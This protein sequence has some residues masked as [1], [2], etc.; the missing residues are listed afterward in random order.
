[1]KSSSPALQIL[2]GPKA[3][4]HLR[5]KGL[6]PTDIA[7]IPGAAGGPK[8]LLLCELDKYVFGSWLPSQPR[9]RSLIGASIGAWR[10]ACACANDPVKAF[11][12]LVQLYMQEQ[13]YSATPSRPEISRVMRKLLSQVMHPLREAA[14]NHSHHRLHILVNR[15]V[16]ALHPAT[17]RHKPGFVRACIANLRGRHHLA[18]HMQRIVFHQGQTST[19]FFSQMFDAFTTH[20][21]PLTADNFDD[22]LLASGSIPLVMEAM[23]DIQGA[24]PGWYW[25]GGIIDYHLHLPYEKLDGLTLYPHFSD[26]IIPG[27]LDKF[28]AWR[29]ARGSWLDTLILLCPSK[30]FVKSLPNGK[31]PDRKDFNRHGNNWQAREKE[32]KKS[33]SAA[34]QLADDFHEIIEKDRWAALAKP[35]HSSLMQK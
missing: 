22:A 10:M 32:W 4:Q 5:E 26:R 35:L 8:G 16:G 31:I 12:D 15:G 1:M 19:P 13:R 6:S 24:P 9:S 2:A 23:R 17:Q 28:L 27:W 30:E 29:K 21:V 11:D 33:L 18:Q 34:Q 7:C 25:D 3:L 14:L 20:R